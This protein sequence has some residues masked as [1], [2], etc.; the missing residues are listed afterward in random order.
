MK[1]L[2]AG[3]G[4][5]KTTKIKKLIDKD[6]KDSKRILV[7]SFTN[8]TVNDLMHSFKDYKNVDC[9]TLHSYSLKINH[10][11]NY[12][13]LAPEE[14]KIIEKYA[15]KL[16][17][18]IDE[19]FDLLKCITFER[20]ISKCV[21][22]IK[23]N[24]DYA[25]LKIGAIDLLIVDEFQDFNPDEQQL[26]HIISSYSKET[27]ILGDDDQS[28]YGFKDA[29]PNGIIELYK[30][31]T[32]ERIPHENICFRCPDVIIE[33]CTKLLSKNKIRIDKEWKKNGKEGNLIIKQTRN[34]DETNN[35][36]ISQIQSIQNTEKEGSILIL[37]PVEFAVSRL[38]ESLFNQ[39]IEFVDLWSN[40][41]DKTILIKIWWI[42]A[43]YS[44]HRFLNLLFLAAESNMYKKVNILEKIKEIIKQGIN[45]S[46][47]LEELIE[48]N[49]FS[50][51]FSKYFKVLIDIEDFFKEN[52]D[53]K[54]LKDHINYSELD[55]SLK[56]LYREFNPHKEFEKSKINLMSIHK[57]KGL[58][59]EYVFIVGLT[60]GIIPNKVKG[61]DS[62]EAQRRLLFVG[63]S[64]A[65]KS[66]YLLTNTEWDAKDI[67]TVDKNQFKFV[68]RKK[69]VGKF[70][71]YIEEIK[72]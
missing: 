2:L 66:L 8:A 68:G 43:I 25:E 28:I 10:L 32:I 18:N 11:L 47:L 60:E 20:M 23:S 9:Y 16:N 72:N 65:L 24:K 22:F 71:S 38:K 44:Q 50:S 53:F 13:I 42:R 35:Y 58:E 45:S 59:S 49:N 51:N 6:Y 3:P 17:Q 48:M 40:K 33:F 19:L 57:S 5:G 56:R 34:V 36:I 21:S 63:L 27:L 15:K 37:S 29:D 14:S 4:T 7:I 52:I 30:N 70:S 67:F 31:T 26:I 41:I 12:H 64:R 1:I 55:D 46:V 61:T 69:V 39:K 54:P 62:I